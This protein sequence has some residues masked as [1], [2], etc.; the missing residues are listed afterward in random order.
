[1]TTLTA[2][3]GL[4]VTL[5]GLLAHDPNLAVLVAAVPFML[6]APL[7][8]FCDPLAHRLYGRLF[9][10]LGWLPPGTTDRITGGK[11]RSRRLR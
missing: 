3:R 9:E 4:L 10:R 6:V 8:G 7:W 11:S 2:L 1:M 5:H